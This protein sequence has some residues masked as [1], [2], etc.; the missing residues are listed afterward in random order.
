MG[1]THTPALRAHFP[2]PAGLPAGTG[3]VWGVL[4]RDNGRGVLAS[5]PP[6]PIRRMVSTGRRHGLQSLEG[7]M[8][9]GYF[10]GPWGQ[11]RMAGGRDSQLLPCLIPSTGLCVRLGRSVSS[12][13]NR[14]LDV[15]T[16]RAAPSQP[17]SP[18]SWVLSSST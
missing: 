7:P 11:D 3:V 6:A 8:G 14:T 15:C 17:P 2:R 18:P 9:R 1:R 10:Q 5:P 12:V 13:R 16:L 4:M